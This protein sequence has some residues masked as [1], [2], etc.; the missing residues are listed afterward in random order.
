MPLQGGYQGPEAHDKFNQDKVSY[1]DAGVTEDYLFN[2]GCNM[3]KQKY[4][5]FFG[6]FSRIMGN[7]SPYQ[8]IV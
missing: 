7:N 1:G 8:P 5:Q 6:L 3:F 2:Q 4:W